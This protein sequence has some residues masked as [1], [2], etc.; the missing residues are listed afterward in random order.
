MT[1]HS[2]ATAREEAPHA[3][4]STQN[5]FSNALRRRAQ[6]VINDKWI[7]AESRAMVRYA[8]EINDPWLPELVRRVDAG[9]TVV[10]IDFSRTPE[11]EDELDGKKLEALTRLICRAGDEPG[12][13]STALLVL[14]ATLENAAHPKV[15]ANTVKHLAFNRCSDLNLSGVVDA[16]VPVLEAELLA[17]QI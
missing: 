3:T 11:N 14:M 13:K 4:E 16:Q 15:L 10:D 7:D 9:E 1:S 12:T 2:S 5:I 17:E 8:L 6:S